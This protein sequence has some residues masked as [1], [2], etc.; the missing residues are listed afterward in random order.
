MSLLSRNDRG[1]V[2][3]AVTVV[4]VATVLGRAIGGDVRNHHNGRFAQLVQ[5]CG[6]DAE[7]YHIKDR[8]DSHRDVNVELSHDMSL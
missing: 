7:H 2:P 1:D 5:R 6:E 3:T 8:E 4:N